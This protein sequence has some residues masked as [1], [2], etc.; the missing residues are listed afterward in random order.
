MWTTLCF[1]GSSK[2]KQAG[3]NFE[4]ALDIESERH[5]SVGLGAT[6]GEGQKIKNYF[7][8]FKDSS[9]TEKTGRRYL[10]GDPRYRIWTRLINIGLLAT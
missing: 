7:S 10:Q 6:L 3:D 8:S 5:W 4:E 2:K 9:K 1:A